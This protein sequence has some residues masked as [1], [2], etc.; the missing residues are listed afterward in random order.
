MLAFMPQ[1]ITVWASAHTSG[2]W[3][4]AF[5]SATA[6]LPLCFL[7]PPFSYSTSSFSHFSWHCTFLFLPKFSHIFLSSV[8]PHLLPVVSCHVFISFSQVVSFIILQYISSICILAVSSSCSPF[9]LDV[10][11]SVGVPAPIIFHVSPLLLL[12]GPAGVTEAA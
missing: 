3:Q 10:S 11:F 8:P 1:L 9:F 5:R 4:E 12:P 2:S 7:C 6:S